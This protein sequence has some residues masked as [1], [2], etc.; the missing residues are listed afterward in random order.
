MNGALIEIEQ[1]KK[2]QWASINDF[3]F[4]L[5]FCVNFHG[6]MEAD[7]TYF[8]PKRKLPSR[9]TLRSI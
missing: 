6:G 1:E 8:F 7:N 3:F 5:I 2:N 4:S 9:R